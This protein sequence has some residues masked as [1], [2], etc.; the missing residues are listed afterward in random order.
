MFTSKLISIFA[1]FLFATITSLTSYTQNISVQP[2]E[3][4][5]DNPTSVAN[6]GDGTGRLYITE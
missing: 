5:L 3:T 6:A 2:I 4:D 1:G